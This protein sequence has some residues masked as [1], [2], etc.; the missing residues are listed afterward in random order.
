MRSAMRSAAALRTFCPDLS[1]TQK[2]LCAKPSSS[3]L[4]LQRGS[5]DSIHTWR[6]HCRRGWALLP[7]LA[8]FTTSS[9]PF[10]T[11]DTTRSSPG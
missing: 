4:S 3:V 11:Q 1:V 10:S 6:L 8:F 9:K 7:H 2:E 5:S